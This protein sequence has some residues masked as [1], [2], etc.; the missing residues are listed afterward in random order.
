MITGYKPRLI[1][2]WSLAALLEARVN[3][4]HTNLAMSKLLLG[5]DLPPTPHFFESR[6]SQV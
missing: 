4:C 3:T 6:V 2:L 1:F 5:V